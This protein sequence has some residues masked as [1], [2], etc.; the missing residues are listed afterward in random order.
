MRRGVEVCTG[1]VTFS[2]MHNLGYWPFTVRN[3][4]G[5]HNIIFL[6]PNLVLININNYFITRI[7]R[8]K[9]QSILSE[10]SFSISVLCVFR[11]WILNANKTYELRTTHSHVYVT[12][13][14]YSWWV[15]LLCIYV[16]LRTCT[17]H[18]NT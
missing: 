14:L 11:I 8:R 3:T 6:L 18:V 9:S 2:D 4:Y 13:S 16:L 10:V 17:F 1:W 12:V 5:V 15:W 7:T